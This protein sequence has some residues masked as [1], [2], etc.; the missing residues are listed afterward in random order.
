MVVVNTD[1]LMARFVKQTKINTK[2]PISINVLSKK[3]CKTIFTKILKK[4]DMGQ[5]ANATTIPRT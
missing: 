4:E 5:C 2:N 3:Q 1:Y